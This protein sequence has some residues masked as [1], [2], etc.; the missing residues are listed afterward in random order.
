MS[1]EQTIFDTDVSDFRRY[2]M[3]TEIKNDELKD[4]SVVES[5]I[6]E[7]EK[8]SKILTKSSEKVTKTISKM[9]SILDDL[10]DM[11]FMDESISEA[12]RSAAII[13]VRYYTDKLYGGEE[14]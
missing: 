11:V 6:S 13:A 9:D 1:P 8:E 5:K 12:D 10:K 4:F 7:L 14:N 2:I 3:S